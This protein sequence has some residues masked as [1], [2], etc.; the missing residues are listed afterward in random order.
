MNRFTP[1]ALVSAVALAT[2]S[3]ALA[4]ESQQLDNIVVTAAGFEQAMAEAPASISVISRQEL[5]EKRVT[6]IAD[7]LRDVEGVDVGGQVGKT[8]GRNISIRGMPSD[9]T[10]ILIDGRRQNTAGSVTPNG[11]GETSTS[12]FPPVSAIE[13]IEVIR[14]PMSTLYGSD[15]MG[16]VINIITRKVGDEW[17]GSVQA[18]S[19]FNEHDEFGDSRETS[20]Y[21]SGPLVEET[22]GLQVR[23]RFY[24][25]DESNLTY[26]D[27][28]GDP[29]PVSQ[30]GP[31]PV[32]GD[33]YSL[34]AKLTLTP[35]ENHDLWLDGE[36][37]RQKFNNDEGQLGTLDDPQGQV[38]GYS[39]ELRFERQQVAIGHTGRFASGTLESSLMRNVTETKGRTIPEVTETNQD[40]DVTAYYGFGEIHPTLPHRPLIGSE[41]ELETT[42][43]VLD[44]KF[45]MP[46]GDHMTTVGGQWMDSELTD[47]LATDEFTQTTWALFAEDEWWLA[48]DWA[49]TLGGRYDHHDAFGSQFSPRGYL[50]W[51]TTDRWTLKGGVSRGYKT[52]S[53]NDLHDG[54]NGITGQGTRLTIGNPDLQPEESTSSELAAQYD[55]GEG[56]MASATLFHNSFDDKITDGDPIYISN[57]SSIPD[58]IYDQLINVD[59]AETQGIELSTRIQLSERVNLSANYTWTDSEQKSGEQQGE[60]LTDTPEHAVNATL[61]WQATDRLGTWLSGEYRSERYRDR[62]RV[63]GAASYDDLGDFESYALFHLGGSYR[64]TNAF[65]VSA[66]VQNLFDKD[67]VDYRAYDGGAEYGNVYANSEEGRRLWLSARYEF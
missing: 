16:G 34:G 42:N 11:F 53:L 21:A 56:F 20:V 36:T 47:G 18:E 27:D 1:R 9:Y 3:T 24:E 29:Q 23:G 62:E 38:R 7:A 26:T 46:L 43:T 10:L 63:R 5:E 57:H 41:R 52:P 44:S 67:F 40:G 15:A 14:G 12:F 6:T 49:L 32:E 54:I 55:D 50:V 51:N 22:L 2:A 4:Q 66:T 19:T 58:G 25:R 65:T 64:V 60:P 33:I 17:S 8:G 31:S 28:N 61:R 48:E 59:E 13:R 30:R 37:S 39:D 45:T 35:N